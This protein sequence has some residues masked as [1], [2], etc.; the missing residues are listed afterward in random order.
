MI[1]NRGGALAGAGRS[2]LEGDGFS[3]ATA[4]SGDDDHR[5]EPSIYGIIWKIRLILGKIN[6]S[7]DNRHLWTAPRGTE[8]SGS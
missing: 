3:N 6:Q 1:A 8:S 2:V 4:G 7:S 5:H